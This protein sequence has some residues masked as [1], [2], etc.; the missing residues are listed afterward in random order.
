MN[1]N[2]RAFSEWMPKAASKRLSSGEV[3][4]KKEYNQHISFVSEEKATAERPA[5]YHVLHRLSEK[6]KSEKVKGIQIFPLTA[7]F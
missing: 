3:K 5:G 7:K 6:K 1:L 4:R 2:L